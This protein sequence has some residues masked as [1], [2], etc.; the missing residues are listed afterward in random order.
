[1]M[2]S[3]FIYISSRWLAIYIYNMY[4]LYMKILFD[5]IAMT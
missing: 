2:E 5:M 4:K 3:Q 1:M